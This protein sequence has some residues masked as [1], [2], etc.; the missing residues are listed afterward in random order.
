[1][2]VK[3][4]LIRKMEMLVIM[5]V[6]I[7]HLCLK[8]VTLTN[9]RNIKGYQKELKVILNQLIEMMMLLIFEELQNHFHSQLILMKD[10]KVV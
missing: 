6:L 9:Y 2:F 10:C 1:M 3:E 8:E 5:L 7:Y 4:R